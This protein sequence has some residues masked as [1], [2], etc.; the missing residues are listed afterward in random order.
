MKL[1]K[2]IQG[3]LAIFLFLS[4]ITY[5][6]LPHIPVTF[7]RDNGAHHDNVPYPI[8]NM[9]EWWYYNGQLTSSSGRHFGY[10]IGLIN[11]I[12]TIF[13]T[14]VLI[15]TLLI[16]LT[17][18]DKNKVYGTSI[19]Y[20]G[21]PTDFSTKKL[22]ISLGK[23]DFVLE[24]K[25]DMHVIN[26]HFKS[27]QGPDIKLFLQMTPTGKEL[28]ES[29]DGVVP[30]GKNYNA[31]YYAFTRMITSG[32]LEIDNEKILITDESNS[33]MEHVWGDFLLSSSFPW[34]SSTIRLDD[35]FD[36]NLVNILD[37]KTKKP[38]KIYHAN[39]RMPDGS[40]VR[41]NTD[42]KVIPYNET[43][44]PQ[45]YEILIPAANIQ[46]NIQSLADAQD[47]NGWWE[48]ISK[49]EGTHNGVPIHG[50]TYM[51]ILSHN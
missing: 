15:P 6:N 48:G 47:T 12:L 28:M 50:F 29:D 4:H 5:A 39:I 18:I 36:I 16:Q 30:V 42:I 19:L 43:P 26:T 3:L 44:Y 41:I 9:T 46:L 22:F 27:K 11:V 51:Q 21:K 13:N 24:D 31:Y 14:K 32:L 33:W 10:S 20:S 35:G 40:H 23:N 8:S 38:S 49:V 17:D 25:F 45:R 37:N 1:R 2:F 34:V 7:P